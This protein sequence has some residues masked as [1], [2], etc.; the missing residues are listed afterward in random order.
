VLF[1]NDN[2]PTFQPEI[3]IPCHSQ[4]IV[5]V[6]VNSKKGQFKDKFQ[7]KADKKMKNKSSFSGREKKKKTQ[8][9]K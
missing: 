1:F 3:D 6:K 7:G 9:K 5:F 2:F 8:R 4:T